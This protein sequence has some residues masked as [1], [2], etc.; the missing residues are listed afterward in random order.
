MVVQHRERARL[1]LIDASEKMLAHARARFAGDSRI[2]FAVAD[3]AIEPI[4]GPWDAIVSALSIH[5]L[6]DDH[7]R[8]LYRRIADALAPGGIF[9]NAELVTA[10]DRETEHRQGKRWVAAIRDV[11]SEE[12]FA[13]TMERTRMDRS[14]SM[15]SQLAWL[16]E[17]GLVEVDCPF[18]SWQFAVLTGRRAA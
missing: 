8:A 17:A 6:D 5:H 15:E 7:K 10:P 2:T 11:M 18:R 12:E 9:I 3:Y 13:A 16:R 1:H 4:G 14:A